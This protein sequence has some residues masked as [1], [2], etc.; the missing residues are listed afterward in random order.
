[1][2]WVTVLIMAVFAVLALVLTQRIG[3]AK[4]A[5]AVRWI[6]EGTPVIDV[7]TEGEFTRDPVPGAIN[8]PLHVVTER[9]P[10]RFPDKTKPVLLHCLSGGRSMVAMRKLRAL[11][12]SQAFNLGSV[13]RA[14]RLV[15]EARKA[16]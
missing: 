1:M 3:Q 14:R 16:S 4:P 2:E 8:M 7:R 5:D 11:G 12:Y 10:S 13:G 15:L 9:F 6:R